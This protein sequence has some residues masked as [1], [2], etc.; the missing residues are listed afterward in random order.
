[1]RLRFSFE[2]ARLAF[3]TTKAGKSADD[4]TVIKAIITGPGINSSVQ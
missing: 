3:D 2:D 1:M 4:R